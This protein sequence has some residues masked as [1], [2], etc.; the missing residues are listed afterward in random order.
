MPSSLQCS[1]EYIEGQ[2]S[3]VS[4]FLFTSLVYF[5]IVA[6]IVVKKSQLKHH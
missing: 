1:I 3:S 5:A 6:A 2:D 4:F